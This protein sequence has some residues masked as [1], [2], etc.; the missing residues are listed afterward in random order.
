[1][2]LALQEEGFFEKGAHTY[3]LKLNEKLD[4]RTNVNILSVYTSE[5]RDRKTN[6]I[7]TD[8]N[9]E[10]DHVIMPDMIATVSY[11]LNV[12]DGFGDT[13][14]IDHLGNRRIRCV[15]DLIQNQF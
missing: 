11:I 2:V 7:G 3:S 13:D 14:D 4:D 1:M 6:I 15:G 5:K 8:L 9:C 12:M 10:S